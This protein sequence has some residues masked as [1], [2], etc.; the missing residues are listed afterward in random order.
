MTRL[1]GT[2]TPE[3]AHHANH[4]QPRPA[5]PRPTTGSK[6]TLD[7]KR[8]RSG[9]ITQA[10]D[11]H[12]SSDLS[13]P[14]AGCT[15][16]PQLSCTSN[17]PLW[18]FIIVKDLLAASGHI[19]VA[20]NRRVL[21]AT[22]FH[23]ASTCWRLPAGTRPPAR[24]PAGN[25]STMSSVIDKRGLLTRRAGGQCSWRSDSL[26]ERFADRACTVASSSIPSRHSSSTPRTRFTI[27]RYECVPAVS[28]PT[29]GIHPRTEAT[30]RARALGENAVAH[31]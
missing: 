5:S 10:A 27:A 18:A 17:S 22:K 2:V 23:P 20:T 1:F 21:R 16:D 9:R 30:T 12:R 25:P 7:T 11:A 24:P 13:V 8:I 6:L 14:Y 28:R 26:L 4:H 19:L 15:C 31:R 3:P 29:P